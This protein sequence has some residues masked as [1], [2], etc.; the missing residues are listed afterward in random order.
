MKKTILSMLL[1]VMTVGLSAVFTSCSDD[2]EDVRTSLVGTTWE[3]AKNSD[4]YTFD[5][6]SET[7][8]KLTKREKQLDSNFDWTNV[9]SYVYYTYTI[10]EN[11][12]TLTPQ[13]N[14]LVPLIG[15]IN[16]NTMDIVNSTTNR[17]IYTCTKV[18]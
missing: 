9:T 8:C 6:N 11:K 2:E 7:T 18:E 5:F 10:N 3:C 13:D 17:I 15:T 14:I 1:A 12:V 16:G 4:L